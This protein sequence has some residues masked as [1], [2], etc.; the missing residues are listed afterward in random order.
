MTIAVRRRLIHG[1]FTL[2][3]EEYD[4]LVVAAAALGVQRDSVGATPSTATAIRH[5]EPML[6]LDNVNDWVR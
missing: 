4:G 5:W 2:S 3:D 6:S 1:W